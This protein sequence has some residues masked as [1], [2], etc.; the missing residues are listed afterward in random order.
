MEG[1]ISSQRLRHQVANCNSAHEREIVCSE[2]WADESQVAAT[3]R[4]PEVLTPVCGV[5]NANPD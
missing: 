1:A 3:R 5:R 4:S 2:L